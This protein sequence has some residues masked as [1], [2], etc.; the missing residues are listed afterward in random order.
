MKR[1]S[2]SRKR[3]VVRGGCRL[4]GRGRPAAPRT[5]QTS[6]PRWAGRVGR[7]A[8]RADT[9]CLCIPGSEVDRWARCFC[10]REL[11]RAL[12]AW[13]HD[14]HAW[15]AEMSSAKGA[16]QQSSDAS[17]RAAPYASY[18]QDETEHHHSYGAGLTRCFNRF[19]QC[20]LA[21]SPWQCVC[22]P[23]EHAR[24]QLLR[25]D[26]IS[27]LQ[28]QVQ[29]MR[30]RLDRW[31]ILAF[32]DEVVDLARVME[33]AAVR[34]QAAWRRRC[35]ALKHERWRCRYSPVKHGTS[36]SLQSV[37]GPS[38]SRAAEPPGS[39]S[40]VLTAARPH[41]EA[42]L[43]QPLGALSERVV[44][45]HQAPSSSSLRHTLSPRDFKM[46]E[47]SMS[48]ICC[49]YMRHAHTHAAPRALP[50]LSVELRARYMLSRPRAF[51]AGY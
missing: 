7:M 1:I 31:E 23:R 36:R 32:E 18:D 50:L 51:I 14:T 30:A 16:Q 33:H 39:P 40:A 11:F 5:P 34:L 15:V 35:A 4:G 45:V 9:C 28:E 41:E 25:S 44:G 20:C 17:L 48:A 46:D 21:Y 3:R 13:A 12:E 8:S 24:L 42:A 27:R 10:W 29:S 2:S 38:M 47:P 22:L 26:A 49:I 43:Q 19:G 6:T 37:G